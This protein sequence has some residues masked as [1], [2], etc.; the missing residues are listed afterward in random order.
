[1]PPPM[2][3]M[4]VLAAFRAAAKPPLLIVA[5]VVL[6]EVHVTLAVRLCVEL[7]LYDVPLA[8]NCCVFASSHR[9]IHWRYRDE[10]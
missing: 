4:V 5:V 2:A 1:M 6:D 8:V 9:W 7:T 10:R 3:E